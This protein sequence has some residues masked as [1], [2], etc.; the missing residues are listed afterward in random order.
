M[1]GK[2]ISIIFSIIAI[3]PVIFAFCACL[4]TS[5]AASEFRFQTNAEPAIC[6][7]YRER[8]IV[9]EKVHGSFVC[10]R[11]L[12]DQS[13]RSPVSWVPV[14]SFEEKVSWLKK[15]WRDGF[16]TQEDFDDTFR[17]ITEANLRHIVYRGKLSLPSGLQPY[18]LAIA[19]ACETYPTVETASIF[20][21]N[22][23]GT[24]LDQAKADAGWQGGHNASF[25]LIENRLFL[26]VYGPRHGTTFF[27]EGSFYLTEVLDA[28]ARPLCVIN[29]K[30]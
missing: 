27:S 14:T 9:A 4:T 15:A 12:G 8:L 28:Q 10:S 5:V 18:V 17:E 1:K 22:K 26:D 23:S 13:T 16:R 6:E 7:K 2:S 25:A 11:Q 21:L 19:Q 24:D 29:F 30:R 3:V 20:F